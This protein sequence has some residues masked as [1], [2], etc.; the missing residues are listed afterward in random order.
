MFKEMKKKINKKE[1]NKKM[2]L[3]LKNRLHFSMCACR[4]CAGAMLIFSALFQV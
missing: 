4:P 1:K 3:K 2:M